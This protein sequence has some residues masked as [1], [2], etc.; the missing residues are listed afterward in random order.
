LSYTNLKRVVWHESFLILLE[1]IILISKTGFAHECYDG[2]LR[3]LFPLI[4]ILSADYE[5]QC[6]MALI[7]GFGSDCPCPVCLVPKKQLTDHSTTYPMRTVEDA[8]AGLQLWS[9][10]RAAGEAELKKQS[11]RPVKVCD[12]DAVSV[13]NSLTG[14]IIRIPSGK[15]SGP[16][17][18]MHL[19]RIPYMLTMGGCGAGICSWRSR[20]TWKRW[21][22][23]LRRNLMTSKPLLNPSSKSLSHISDSIG[24]KPFHD[25]E[26]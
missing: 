8:Q 19:H 26:T 3:W 12:S 6:V 11:L 25:G 17:R 22:V 2:I 24:L 21:G 18:I 13:L 14:A 23:P 20:H 1:T 10:D 7:R 4:L 5:E 9:R 15:S 16:T